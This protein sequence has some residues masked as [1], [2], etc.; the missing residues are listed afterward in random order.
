MAAEP[1]LLRPDWPAP[2]R[3]RAAVTTRRGGVSAPPF[4]SLNLGDHVGDTADAVVEN[5][6][7]L[8]N[9]LGLDRP[10]AWL[11][12][13]HGRRVVPAEE[14]PAQ[15]DGA[16]TASAGLACVV[17]TADCLPVLFCDDAG[18]V[19]AAAHA[20]WRGLADGV[21]EAVVDA[22]P[23]APERL[24]AWLGP[25]IGPSAFEV[26]E[27]VRERFLGVDPGAEAAFLPSAGG[28]WLADLYALA[29]QRLA[30]AGVER[31]SGGGFCTY[32]DR[33]QFYSYRRDGRTGRMA[34]LVWLQD[35]ADGSA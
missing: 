5:R 29:R 22:L 16:W 8:L 34:A 19:V 30:G 17:L 3:V 15:A 35:G 7:R 28:R 14:A 2:E 18:S 20:G 10:P 26:G 1:L 31:I 9:S 23:V 27:E 25:A 21:L 33:A 32:R 12:Q 6:R 11:N 4:A 13:V 24:L